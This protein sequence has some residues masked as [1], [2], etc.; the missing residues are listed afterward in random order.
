ML[1]GQLLLSG[2]GANASTSRGVV[3]TFGRSASPWRSVPEHWTGAFAHA[4][5][6]RGYAPRLLPLQ[7]GRLPAKTTTRRRWTTERCHRP[8]VVGTRSAIGTAPS[9][10]HTC[11]AQAQAHPQR[12]DWSTKLRNRRARSTTSRRGPSCVGRLRSDAV[13]SLLPA[14]CRS[15]R[16]ASLLSEAPKAPPRVSAACSPQA[17]G[18][19]L[20]RQHVQV[21]AGADLEAGELG[22]P[23]H[24]LDPP[25]EALGIPAALC[26]P[27][28]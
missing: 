16:S 3:G 2:R 5:L 7:L 22:E 6:T 21:H 25:A 9:I 4:P 17:L 28:C 10:D 14:R 1:P 27:T 20:R 12:S 8:I 18:R 13:W 23:R 26:G 11:N 19:V 15:C 24:H